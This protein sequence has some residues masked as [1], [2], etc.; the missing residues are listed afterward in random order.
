L[1][2]G[3]DT[4]GFFDDL[5]NMV[6][7]PDEYFKNDDDDSDFLQCSDEVSQFV[8][9]LEQ[10]YDDDLIISAFEEELEGLRKTAEVN[11]EFK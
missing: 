3:L 10:R 8:N 11:R 6:D 5:N 7:N 1:K 2:E 9:E 4:Q